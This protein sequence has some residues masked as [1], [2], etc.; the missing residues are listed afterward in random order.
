MS[1]AG[2]GIKKENSTQEPFRSRGAVFLKNTGAQGLEVLLKE[3]LQLSAYLV[4]VLT[5][6]GDGDGFTLLYRHAHE[7]HEL[8][9]V[10]AL[11]A[12]GDGD[13]GAHIAL[14]LLGHDAGGTGMEPHGIGDGVLELF[15]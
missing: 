11:V 5:L 12:L 10:N 7:A 8:Q 13:G 2:E 14:D 3:L 4:F 6:N 9:S 1:G 15:H